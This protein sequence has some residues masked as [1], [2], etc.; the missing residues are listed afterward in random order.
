MSA[1]SVDDR[2]LCARLARQAVDWRTHQQAR[3]CRDSHLCEVDFG[4]RGYVGTFV[5]LS[6]L[7]V[8]ARDFGADPLWTT[9]SCGIEER[10]E[11]AAVRKLA[12]E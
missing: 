3:S 7:L 11:I 6:V 9:P 8:Q 5:T 4:D 1:V 10:P 12:E 2:T